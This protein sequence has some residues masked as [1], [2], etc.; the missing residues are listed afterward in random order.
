[1]PT[2]NETKL[3]D[4]LC[5]AAQRIRLLEARIRQLEETEE[6]H[7]GCL[8]DA[9]YRPSPYSVGHGGP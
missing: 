8:R 6:E 2:S 9:Q 7:M 1:M 3:R 4:A 5:I